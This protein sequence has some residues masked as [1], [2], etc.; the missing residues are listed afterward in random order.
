MR[1]NVFFNKPKAIFSF[2]LFV[3][4]LSG[5]CLL[6]AYQYQINTDGVAYISVAQRYLNGDFRGAVNGY[7]GPLFSWLLVPILSLGLPPLLAA[8]ILSALIGLAT[9]IGI[10]LLSQR[11]ELSESHQNFMLFSLIPIILFFAFFVIT[12][13][14]LILCVLLYYLAVIFNAAYH[15]GNNKGALCGLLGS[16]AYFAKSFGLPFFLAHFF[17]FNCWHYR[18]SATTAEKKAVLR[19]FGSGLAV[20]VILSGSWIYLLSQKYQHFTFSTSA[21]YSLALLNSQLSPFAVSRPGLLPPPDSAAISAWEDPSFKKFQPQSHTAASDGWAIVSHSILSPP[22]LLKLITR[23]RHNAPVLRKHLQS[24]SIFSSVIILVAFLSCFRFTKIKPS[25]SVPYAL[26]TLAIYGGG[27]SLIFLEARYMWIASI[28]VVL[29]GF[30]LLGRLSRQVLAN[31]IGVTIILLGFVLSYCYKPIKYLANN[32]YTGRNLYML[33]K[34]LRD[35]YDIR[36]HIAS[37]DHWVS[38]TGLAFYN[39]YKYFGR[40]GE[41][42]TF[43]ELQ[44]ELQDHDI[45]YYFVMSSPLKLSLKRG[46]AASRR[47]LARGNL[48]HDE[49]SSSERGL[50]DFFSKYKEITNG[51][52]AGLRI[53]AL[54]EAKN[55]EHFIF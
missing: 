55:N 35:N 15:R 12:P 42:L 34:K 45:D 16:F 1:R 28:L 36:G 2:T 51:E 52:I 7:W 50:I 29:S 47:G 43:E 37:N 25:R 24:F 27:Y 21:T 11:F 26:V 5:L 23:V 3:F 20:F 31:K 54:K 17:F 6:A 8:K 4:L 48:F 30:H 39:R 33:S 18:R 49:F 10:R 46:G 38:L 32:L 44:N 9:L 53:Y 22:A 13:D 40:V 41:N 19:N 14:L